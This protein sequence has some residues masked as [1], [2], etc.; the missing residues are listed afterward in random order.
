MKPIY[1]FDVLSPSGK[2]CNVL[3]GANYLGLV[4]D[5]LYAEN[6]M[7]GKQKLR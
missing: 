2:P 1:A 5:F 3:F 4:W 6:V 7:T